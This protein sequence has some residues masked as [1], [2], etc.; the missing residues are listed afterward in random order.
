MKRDVNSLQILAFDCPLTQAPE[1]RLD[2]LCASGRERDKGCL[3]TPFHTDTQL[4]K[5]DDSPFRVPASGLKST[6]GV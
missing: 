5:L 2:V 4:E 6:G 3:G 1:T